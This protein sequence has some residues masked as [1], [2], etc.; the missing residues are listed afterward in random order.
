MEAITEFVGLVNGFVWG[1]PM[2]V[3]IL[4]VGLF[5]SLGLR[6]M[7]ILKLGTGFKLLWSGRIPDKDKNVKGDV[8]P[9]NA[10]MTSLSATI[11]TGNIAGLLP[12][13]LLEALVPYFG[14]GVQR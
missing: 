14:C 11:G 10:L 4:G 3:M 9:F 2:L 7:P 13:F 6:L 1:T 12:R 8:S 5:L